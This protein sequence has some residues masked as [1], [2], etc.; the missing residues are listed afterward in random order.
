MS[1]T[2]PALN[3][4]KGNTM[5]ILK[6]ALVALALLTT[7]VG[8]QAAEQARPAGGKA[9]MCTVF[10]VL[11]NHSGKDVLVCYVGKTQKPVLHA[12]GTF[13]VIEIELADGASQELAIWYSA[14][15]AAK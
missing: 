7:T 10:E 3:A 5:T 13:V 9:N 4:E 12:A 8:A 14:P 1:R 6:T 11:G 15:K 2:Q